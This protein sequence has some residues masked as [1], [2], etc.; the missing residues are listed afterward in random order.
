M[1][2]LLLLF[3][4]G[5]AGTVHSATLPP[6]SIL[7]GVDRYCAKA[8][9]VAVVFFNYRSAGARESDLDKAATIMQANNNP[10]MGA[11]L[12]A[13]IKRLYHGP[14]PL[15]TRREVIAYTYRYC[16]DTPIPTVKTPMHQVRD[17][18][19]FGSANRVAGDAVTI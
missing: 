1:K 3:A 17:I 11:I 15:R 2:T 18:G 14:H 6:A 8:A 5:L 13:V 16:M 19:W 12:K 4:L 7:Y 9:Q 10:G